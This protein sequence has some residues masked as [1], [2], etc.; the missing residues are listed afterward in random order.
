MSKTN[1]GFYLTNKWQIHLRE[2][3]KK[4]IPK[5]GGGIQSIQKDF[6]LIFLG[7]LYFMNK[8]VLYTCKI[9]SEMPGDA[10]G[11]CLELFLKATFSQSGF[12]LLIKKTFVKV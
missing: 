8:I 6:C 4:K 5:S 11:E 9:F 2:A 1:I 12:L 10:W 7:V 3:F